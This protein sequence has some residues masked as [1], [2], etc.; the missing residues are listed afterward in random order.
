MRL[1]SR[2]STDR[3]GSSGLRL[4]ELMTEERVRVNMTADI[5]E[6]EIAG[7]TADSRAVA[8]GYLFA[9]LPGATHDGRAFIGDAVARGASIV[10]APEDT[11]AADCPVPLITSAD[12]RASLAHMAAAFYGRQPETMAAVTGTNGKTSVAEFTRQIWSRTGANAASIG[13]LG[14]HLPDGTMRPSLTTPDPVGLH[15]GLAELADLGV[16]H[17][18]MEASSHG[19]DQRRLDGVKL[20]AAG[21]TNLSRDHLDYHGSEQAYLAAK[22]RLFTDLL[23][24]TGTAVLNADTPE[25]AAIADSTAATVVSYGTAGAE[26]RLIG[27]A[28]SPGGQHLRLEAFGREV[29]ID[30]PLAGAFQAHNALCA[31][32]L[33]IACG[34]DAD[35]AFDALT[36]LTGVPGRLQPAGTHPS[37]AT[38]LIDYAHTP[39]AL[40]TV[41]MALR[42]HCQNRLLVVFGCGGDRDPGKRPMMGRIAATHADV[43]VVTDDNP[44]TEDAAAIRAEIVAAAPDSLEI[45]DRA[46]AIADAVAMLTA[47]DVLLIAGKGHETGQIVGDEVRP[48]DDLLV[49]RDAITAAGGS[50][51]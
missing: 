27:A 43:S 50:V 13:T 20:Q 41:L 3:H 19:L 18:V 39:D 44:R 7:L 51:S 48:F 32:G 29:E 2:W 11:D 26:L 10:L 9:A 28:P 35:Q 16:D 25:F 17:A 40:E 8:P 14:L 42:A 30:L 38:V 4:V 1:H 34:T 46:T 31:A 47:G 6:T 49:A 22:T 12:A 36:H 33:A 15:A 24:A 5:G 45:G 23:P 21:F 37:G